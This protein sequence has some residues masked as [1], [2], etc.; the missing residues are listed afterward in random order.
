MTETW[1]RAHTALQRIAKER[2]ALDHEEG[3]WLLV[4]QRERAHERLG[5]GSF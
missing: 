4:A 2:A 3:R 5:F 1:Q